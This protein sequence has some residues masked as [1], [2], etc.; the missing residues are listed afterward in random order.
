MALHV[1]GEADVAAGGGGLDD[2][3]V[4]AQ[5]ETAFVGVEMAEIAGGEGEGERAGFAGV[6]GD[7]AEGFEFTQRAAAGR[8]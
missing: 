2:E 8:G 7:F 3:G 5:D 6:Q 1:G 4:A